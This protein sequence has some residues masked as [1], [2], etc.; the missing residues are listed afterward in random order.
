M[1][2]FKKAKEALNGIMGKINVRAGAPGIFGETACLYCAST[3]CSRDDAGPRSAILETL[4][5]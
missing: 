3:A 5:Q 4:L 1:S 2:G